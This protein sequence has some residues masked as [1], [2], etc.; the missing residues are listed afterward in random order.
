M[1]N[2]LISE[3]TDEE[4]IRNEKKLKILTIMLG[5]SM[6]LLFFASMVLM[7]TKGFNPI[8][9]IPICLLPLLIVNIINWQNLKKE[10]QRRN[11]Q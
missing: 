11:V 5:A 10:K 4:L 3:Y 1:R 9:T 8:M 6:V 7:L 2:K